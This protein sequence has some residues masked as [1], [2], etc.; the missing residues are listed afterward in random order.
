MDFKETQ[1]SLQYQF[2]E[3]K[4]TKIEIDNNFERAFE[5]LAEYKGMIDGKKSELSDFLD[6]RLKDQ[7]QS[8]ERKLWRV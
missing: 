6:N 2:T 1:T 4:G 5:K 7:R 8:F 3:F